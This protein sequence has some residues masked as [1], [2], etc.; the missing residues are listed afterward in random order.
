[1]I[2]PQHSTNCKRQIKIKISRSEISRRG[3]INSRG[4]LFVKLAKFHKFKNPTEDT[5]RNN[6]KLKTE[7]YDQGSS[8]LIERTF[9]AAEDPVNR[10]LPSEEAVD[11]GL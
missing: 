10:L 4:M 8:Y 1:M 3:E 2:N 7:N 5:I 9:A 6:S 11:I